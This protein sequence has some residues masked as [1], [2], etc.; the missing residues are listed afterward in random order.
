M[1]ARDIPQEL[2]DILDERAG[3]KHSREGSVVTTL[4]EILTRYDELKG[5]EMD[6]EHTASIDPPDWVSVRLREAANIVRGDGHDCA[7]GRVYDLLDSLADRAEHIEKVGIMPTR[8]TNWGMVFC[9]AAI[10]ASGIV[11]EDKGDSV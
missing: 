2:V 4:A 11:K 8:E 7:I 6:S 3:R 1:E 5:M 10:F 9:H